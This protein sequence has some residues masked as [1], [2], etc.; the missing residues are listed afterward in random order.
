MKYKA[1]TIFSLIFALTLLFA[2]CKIPSS[3]QIDT[4]DQTQGGDAGSTLSPS[5]S[6][7]TEESA[8]NTVPADSGS[9]TKAPETEAPTASHVHIYDQK[10]ENE[11]YLIFTSDESFCTA[12]IYSCKCGARG[13]S[14]VIFGA[15]AHSGGVAT[16][17]ERAICEVC[18][19]EYGEKE[20]HVFDKEVRDVKY[21]AA[22]VKCSY[23]ATF[24]KSCS[25]GAASD[26]ET[27][28]T[29]Y[30]SH[31]Y[32]NEVC[33]VCNKGYYTD[34]LIYK[35]V[36]SNSYYSVVGPGT[37]KDEK[38]IRIPPSY[39]GIII[40][41]IVKNGLAY[42]ENLEELILSEATI[43]ID[44]DALIGTDNIKYVTLPKNSSSLEFAN[45][46]KITSVTVIGK[47]DIKRSFPDFRSPL[48]E[49]LH[50]TDTTL[51]IQEYTLVSFKFRYLIVPEGTTE[52]GRYSLASCKNL[53]YIELP[54]T[55]KAIG[56]MAFH[57]SGLVDIKIPLSVTSFEGA[58]D[59]CEQLR[60]CTIPI[61]DLDT[62]TTNNKRQEFI[63]KLFGEGLKYEKVYENGKQV[64][65]VYDALPD[66][67]TLYGNECLT[68]EIF[69]GCDDLKKLTIDP[70][71]ELT[72]EAGAFL[73]CTNLESLSIPY[74]IIPE[75]RNGNVHFCSVFGYVNDIYTSHPIPKTLKE[76]YIVDADTI[77]DHFFD[78]CTSIERIV[79]TGNVKNIGA[80][81]FYG[82]VNL[83]EIILPD[84]VEVIGEGAFMGCDS[85]EKIKLPSS[86]K[87]IGDS[88]FSRCGLKY[89]DI[90]DSVNR[91]G[92][93]AFEICTRLTAVDLP[94]SLK[95]ID[96]Y[97][98][99]EC[100]SL[101]KIIYEGNANWEFY[102]PDSD[103]SETVRSEILSM[104]S[105]LALALRNKLTHGSCVTSYTD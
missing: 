57:N 92:A 36:G 105:E 88:A 83:K 85:L 19:R 95:K 41:N 53:S 28:S 43:G 68:S 78:G 37:A 31:T 73:N 75:N 99:F 69:L 7:T 25:C 89:V 76:V 86:L 67:I 39:N 79:I 49:T 102:L 4:P 93:K 3:P 11:E 101:K 81:A 10:V 42:C 46:E 64:V 27:F 87:E 84:S 60:H 65:K 6:I 47:G 9:E 63:K 15:K 14:K 77:P 98:F 91:I 58:L 80:Y 30:D 13:D 2:S 38:I 18:G 96:M 33:T 12:Y 21:L 34:G 59:G 5:D 48:L 66:S 8:S 16:C 51:Q 74:I 103:S 97:A 23:E 61:S 24:K 29:V 35:L 55:L 52:I 26:S 71:S 17:T 50:L 45:K 82:C 56:P 20:E 100:N 44:P 70:T 72:I 40:R 22:D 54:S 104:P 62:S 90:P 94:L 32:Q 1:F